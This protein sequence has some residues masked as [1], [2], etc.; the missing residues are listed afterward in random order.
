M[1]NEV[2]QVP[3]IIFI[4]PYRNRPQHK[5]FFSNYLKTIM[6]DRNDYELYFSHQSDNRPF[7]RGG[8]KNIGFLAIKNKYP[9]FYKDITFVFNDID[10]IPFSAIF[11]FETVHG[12]I[13][14]FYGFE[15]ALGGI[16]SIKGSDFEAT[17]GYP[18]FWGWGMEDTV[19]QNRCQRIGLKID[20][21]QFY[22]IGSPNIIHLFDGVSRTINRDESFRA[23][24][25]NGIDGLR[26]IHNLNYEIGDDSSNPLDNINIVDSS[27]FFIINIMEF[28][29]GINS[30]NEN[31]FKYDL[32]EPPQKINGFDTMN[33]SNIIN[34]VENDW[35]N[36]PYYPNVSQRNK[37]IET[38]GIK[39]AAEIIKY[40]YNKSGNH[41]NTN[42]ASY[43]NPV[44]LNEIQRY[45]EFLR[46]NNSNQRIIPSN[47]NKFSPAYSRLIA[48]KPKANASVNIRMGGVY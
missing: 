9:D 42:T 48:A 46:Q 12:I 30:E 20:R 28:I 21:S 38:Y 47:I 27:N 29:T 43:E 14:H 1:S 34:H 40:N 17:N 18:N 36:I 16:V 32:R 6:E 7:N 15:Y 25:D 35:T 24:N 4:V 19:L 31:Y 39:K 37:L 26:T 11:D 8:T 22:Q 10:T 45:N 5:F 3:K 23:K 13:K 44:S 2:N 41:D 33:N